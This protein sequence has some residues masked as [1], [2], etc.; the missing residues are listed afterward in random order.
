MGIQ[1]IGRDLEIARRVGDDVEVY[2][3][4]AG[5]CEIDALEVLARVDRRIDEVLETDGFERDRVTG[6]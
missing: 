1:L 5:G 4:A 6:L 2:G 3:R